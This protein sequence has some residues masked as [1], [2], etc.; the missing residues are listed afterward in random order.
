MLC[1]STVKEIFHIFSW[2]MDFSRWC[3]HFEVA[4]EATPNYDEDSLDKLL[5]TRLGGAAF[6]YWDSLSDATKADCTTVKEKLKA[7]FGKTAYQSTFQS[8][9]NARTHLPGEALS[10]FAAEI[11]HQLEEAF[12]TYGQNAKDGEKFR[13]F[14]AGIEPYLQHGVMNM[15]LQLSSLLLSLHCRLRHHIMLVKCFHLQTLCRVFLGHLLHLLCFLLHQLT[16][17]YLPPLS[18]SILP[19]PMIFRTLETLSERVEQLQLEV[20]CQRR[21]TRHSSSDYRARQWSPAP[22]SGQGHSQYYPSD[23]NIYRDS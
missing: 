10:V 20:Q 19:P 7:V 15:V 2:V 14:I 3:R 13:R 17:L 4:V 6:S 16:F 8:Y 18:E 11:S 12:P 5:P 22:D 1:H 23:R 21:D 9:V